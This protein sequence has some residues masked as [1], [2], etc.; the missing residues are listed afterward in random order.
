MNDTTVNNLTINGAGSTGGGQYH[1][2]RI[3]GSG[4]ITG[5]LT[6]DEFAGNGSVEVQGLLM[7]RTLAVHG[8]GNFHGGV[9][10][11]SAQVH[12][13][14]AV[15]G[16][17]AVRDLLGRGAV[18]LAGGLTAEK[19]DIKGL[20]TIGGDC[21]AETFTAKG[22][23]T[24]GGLL[25]ADTVDVELYGDCRVREI[26]GSTIR[27]IHTRQLFSGLSKLI[28]S[29]VNHPHGGL[30]VDSVEGDEVTLECTRAG[31]VRGK[32]VTIGP[33]CE[34]EQLEYTDTCQIDPGATVKDTKQV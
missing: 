26:G 10:A 29:L 6:C 25:N 14:A 12:G 23:F 8:E 13:R 19:V 22:R 2:V 7:T 9:K 15:Q 16:D 28:H 11:D 27:V 20:L 1:A 18:E 17:T 34:I 30:V 5:E 21:S 24:I 33:E 32:R 3:N 4:T 31:V